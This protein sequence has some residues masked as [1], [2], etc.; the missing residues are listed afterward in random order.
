M[1][2]ADIEAL[3]VEFEKQTTHIV[4]D[5]RMELNDQNVC[6]DLYK[7]GCVLEKI[8]AANESFLQNLQYL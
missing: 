1:L 5:T 4:E 2:M 6:G 3:K 8:K 7:S